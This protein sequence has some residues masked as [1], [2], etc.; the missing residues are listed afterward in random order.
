[1]REP[2]A[3]SAEAL[4]KAKLIEVQTKRLLDEALTGSFRSPFKG[5]GLQFA[6]H[7]VY[8]PGDDVRHI[9]WK[10][11]ARTK[12]PLIKKY[13]EERELNVFLVVDQSASG[14]F[15]SGTNTKREA[16]QEVAAMIAQATFFS[17]EKI[18]MIGFDR[19]VNET[20]AP[21][22]GRA[23]LHRV[24]AGVFAP[25]SGREGTDLRAALERVSKVMK[26]AGVIFIVSDFQAA[27]YETNLRRLTRKH[28]VVAVRVKDAQELKVPNIGLLPFRDPETG[29]TTLVDTGSYRFQDWQ[30]R[31][32]RNFEERTKTLFKK[33]GV[34]EL[35]IET[36]NDLADTVVRFFSARARRR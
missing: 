11:S 34:E 14:A 31:E 26:H 13:D 29:V 24:M 30:R 21:K 16:I 5:Q 35:P 3:L 9:D 12:E 6:E 17:G 23:H 19:Q 7:R 36:R 1:M 22:K 18:G 25:D 20:L 8:V 32:N 15:G 33:C 4:K 28:D 27:D 2:R 10:A